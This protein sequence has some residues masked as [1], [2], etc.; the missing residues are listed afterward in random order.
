MEETEN[1][2]GF[3][4]GLILGEGDLRV[5]DL[6]QVLMTVV[7]DWFVE[8]HR[9]NDLLFFLERRRLILF[10]ISYVFQ[11]L[12]LEFFCAVHEKLTSYSTVDPKLTWMMY[13]LVWIDFLLSARKSSCIFFAVYPFIY[14][15]KIVCERVRMSSSDSV[16][17]YNALD[18]RLAWVLG[19]K[20][21]G[22]LF[23]S[24]GIIWLLPF[25]IVMGWVRIETTWLL[26]PLPG[27]FSR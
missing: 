25:E 24:S 19:P 8:T 3:V 17:C 26:V 7:A 16:N 14:D 6:V 4:V 22:W 1:S 12:P 27:T 2:C 9:C 5:V 23:W 13:L 20:I 15:V 21:W 18:W 11:L 10:F